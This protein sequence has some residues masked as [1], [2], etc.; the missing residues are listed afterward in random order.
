MIC[1][2]LKD[3]MVDVEDQVKP[4]ANNDDG[5]E[6]EDEKEQEEEKKEERKEDKTLYELNLVYR[7]AEKR[8]RQQPK[9]YIASSFGFKD[10]IGEGVTSFLHAFYDPSYD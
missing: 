7:T 10:K 2:L 9:N 1:D 5:E 4:A 8:L 3:N 6:D